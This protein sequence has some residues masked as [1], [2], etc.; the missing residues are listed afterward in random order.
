MA[1]KK[2][3]KR[4]GPKAMSG[5]TPSPASN[6]TQRKSRLSDDPTVVPPSVTIHDGQPLSLILKES[7][8]NNDDLVSVIPEGFDFIHVEIPDVFKGGNVPWAM[9]IG[10]KEPCVVT[11]TP[12][13]SPRR[14]SRLFGAGR[15]TITI[16]PSNDTRPRV[17]VLNN[18]DLVPRLMDSD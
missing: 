4:T 6:K 1:K 8:I 16:R 3:A 2:T 14:R 17:I 9:R 15:L 11:W 5:R 13:A 7:G 10:T 18:V 12:R